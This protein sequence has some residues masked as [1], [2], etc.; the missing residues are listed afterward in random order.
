MCI[1]RD[2]LACALFA[3]TKYPDPGQFVHLYPAETAPTEIVTG[4]IEGDVQ[5]VEV[6]SLPVE[7]LEQVEVD[8]HR[9]DGGAEGEGEAVPLDGGEGE[10][11]NE[12]GPSHHAHAAVGPLFQV[13]VGHAWVELDAA[14]E[15]VDERPVSLG[16]VGGAL[17]D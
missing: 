8:Q 12:E 2:L 17:C 6:A 3:C 14:V 11:G 4:P 15:V 10:D 9:V 1:V 16:V 7:E 5:R 13:D